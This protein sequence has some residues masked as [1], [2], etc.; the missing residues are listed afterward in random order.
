MRR[1]VSHIAYVDCFS[2]ASGDM[3]LGA[4]LDAGLSFDE[5][6][7]DVALLG[8]PNCELTVERKVRHGIY[9]TKFDVLDRG[10]DRPAHNLPAVRSIIEGSSLPQIVIT[11][12]LQVF[13]RIARAEARVHGVSVEEIHFH[14]LGAVDS[15]VDIVGFCVALHRLEIEALYASPLPV[16]SGVV[17]TEHGPLPVPAPATLALLAEVGAPIIPSPARSELV[18]PTGAALLGTLAQFVQPAMKVHQVGYGFG[19]KEFEWPNL[20]RIWIGEPWQSVSSQPSLTEWPRPQAAPHEQSHSNSH[21]HDHEHPHHHPHGH[22]DT[23]GEHTVDACSH[24]TAD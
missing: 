15:L 3:L 5:L 4:W 22:H 16:G 1:Q 11:R 24:D 8:L 23:D 12:S 18:T 6:Q 10:H 19:T 21:G 9:G 7:H 17:R 14:E 20:L 13:E 2:G